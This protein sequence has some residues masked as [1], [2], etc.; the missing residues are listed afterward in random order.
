MK[1][2]YLF[3]FGLLAIA[4]GL[5]GFYNL[6]HNALTSDEP[7]Y[8]GAAYSYTQGLGLNPEHPLFIKLLNS[9][10]I[11]WQ[12]PQIQVPLP[13]PNNL[14]G[15]QI[16][17]AAFEVGYQVLMFFPKQFDSLIR[18]SRLMYLSVNSFL[19]IW[20]GIYTFILK[21]LNPKITLIFTILLIFS[22]SFASHSSL[23]AF[24]VSVAASSLMT[25]LTLA[26]AIHST[27][28]LSG[29]YLLWQFLILTFNLGFAI[30]TKF[31]NLLLLPIILV[32]LT[33]TNIHLF[34]NR[35]TKLGFK[36]LS[37]SLLS[38]GLQ[39][40]F[41]FGVYRIAFRELPGQS[42]QDIFNRYLMG[43][44]LTQEV[45]KG[46]QIPFLNGQFRAV[47]YGQYLSKVIWFKENPV[48]FFLII[49]ILV[50]IIKAYRVFGK[51]Q[52]STKIKNIQPPL[53][54]LSSL[55]LLVGTYPLIY[56]VLAKDSHFI[57]GYRYFYPVLIFLY[58]LMAVLAVSLQA[59]YSQKLLIWGLILYAV[60]GT[61]AVPQTLSY[62]NPLWN[63]DKWLLSNDSTINWGQENRRVAQF[64]LNH[65]LLPSVN[66][67]NLIQRTF[68]TVINV[69]QY[70]EIIARQKDYPID[71]Q[72]YYQ[73]PRFDPLQNEIARLPHQYLIIDSTVLQDIYAKRENQAIAQKNWDYLRKHRPMYS[74][75]DIMFIYQLH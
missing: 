68:G 39:P 52:F 62:V 23:I 70:L 8:L 40:L 34:V 66:Q 43:I 2:N 28:Q 16:R 50:A 33:I 5:M 19:L 45:A 31:S 32:A 73:Q 49:L 69:N 29:K 56:V 57:L 27:T 47:N 10:L 15:N 61:I 55:I 67:D 41:I 1:L 64:L 18:N 36:F 44:Q 20:L 46:E 71:I 12:F 75:N 48:L 11:Q 65:Q 74:H 13:N 58:F 4:Y 22:P 72:S 25:I 37:L 30:N 51:Q 53:Q 59:Y 26:I 3:C 60:A 38:L 9:L 7:A 6:N 17:L 54:Y 35:K 24:D 21:L 63:Q 42:L 14:E